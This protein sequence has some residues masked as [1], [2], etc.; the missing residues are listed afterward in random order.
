LNHAD[1]EGLPAYRDAPVG[2]I[3]PEVPGFFDRLFRRRR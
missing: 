1:L 2:R 3:E